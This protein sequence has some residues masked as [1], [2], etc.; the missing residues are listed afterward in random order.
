V[1][2]RINQ[3]KRLQHLRTKIAGDLHDEIGSNLVRITMLADQASSRNNTS[4]TFITIASISRNAISTIKDVVW[5]IDARYDTMV[6]MID[7]MQEHM[8]NMLAPADIDFSFRHDGLPMEGKLNMSFR[9]NVYLIYKESINNIVKHA[10]ATEVNVELQSREGVFIMNIKDNGRGMRHDKQR[11]GH[12]LGN[13]QLRASRIKG[14]LEI[15]SH[16]G[17]VTISLEAPYKKKII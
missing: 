14:K 2:Y 7:Y 6:G 17:G 12:G 9:Q 16:E 15:R 8:H 13:M 4:D 1:Q 11:S 10:C 3:W 5:S